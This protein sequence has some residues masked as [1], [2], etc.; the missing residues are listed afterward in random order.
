MRSRWGRATAV[1]L[2]CAVAATV[3][4]WSGPLLSATA[5][6]HASATVQSH[7]RTVAHEL[8]NK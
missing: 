6:L 4:A 3:A 8:K 2:L 1:G 7:A 5:G